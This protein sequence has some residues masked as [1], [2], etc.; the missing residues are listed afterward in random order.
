[1]LVVIFSILTPSR[2]HFYSSVLGD[3][4]SHLGWAGC[5]SLK[6][7]SRRSPRKRS[8]MGGLRVGN[9]PLMRKLQSE[10]P[11]L[12]IARASWKELRCTRALK[13]NEEKSRSSRGG[14]CA[15]LDN[16]TIVHRSRGQDLTRGS[17][18]H[19]ITA[20]LGI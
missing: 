14:I 6:A 13:L 10:M 2:H 16:V 4:Y 8:G 3:G 20:M 12:D 19:N 7:P 15:L 9:L 11:V 1:M 17:F 5:I 18:F